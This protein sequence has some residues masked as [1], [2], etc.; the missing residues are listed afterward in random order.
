MIRIFSFGTFLITCAFSCFVLAEEK[1]ETVNIEE[2]NVIAEVLFKDSTKMSP[3]SSITADELNSINITTVEDS[4]AYQPSLIVRKRYIGDPNGVIGIRGSNMFQTPR[5]L[6]FV[7]GMPIHYHLQ[8][9]WNGAPR[10]SLVSPGEISKVDVIYGPFSAEYSGNAMGGVVNIE[11]KVAN[12]QKIRL[13]GAVF[14]QFFERFETNENYTGRNLFASYENSFDNLGFFASYNHLE[15]NSHPMTFHFSRPSNRTATT[16]AV[17]GAISGVDEEGNPGVFYGDSG[18]ELVSTDQYKVKLNYDAGNFESRTIVVF[19]NR[20]RLENDSNNYLRDANGDLIFDRNFSIAGDPDGT[21]YDTT[22]FGTSVFQNR[23]QDRDSLLFGTGISGVIGSSDWV[24][25]SFYSNFQILDDIEVRTGADP[26]DPNFIS[27]NESFRARRTEYDDTGW[28]IF[29]FKTGT[30]SLL[31]INALRLSIGYHYDLYVLEINPVNFNSITGERGSERDSSGGET[32]TSALFVQLGY[33]FSEEWNLALGLRYENWEARDGFIGVPGADDFVEVPKRTESG[34]SPKF[35]IAYFP[36]E[37][38]EIRYSLAR[39]LRFPIVEELFRNE[40][41]GVAQI[42]PDA[43]LN[44]ED[45]IHQ[46]LS[47]RHTLDRGEFQV[48]LFHEVIDDAI[49]TFTEVEFNTQITTALPTEEVTTTGIEFVYSADNLFNSNLDAQL[50][51][52]YANSEITRNALNPDIVGNQFPRMPDWRSNAILRY[53]FSDSFNIS[54]S[55]RYASNSFG[56]L[57]NSD[58]ES[59][60]FGA[61]DEFLLFGL[62]GNWKISND[63]QIGLG[64]ENV[65]DEEVYVHHPWPSRTIFLQGKFE[66]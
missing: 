11:T 44:P 15:N 39:A 48:N 2:V 4:I 51:V 3:T 29:D 55:V 12:E 53:N 46:N 42:V 32:T 49:F 10:W 27:A 13:E 22:S 66:F 20:D 34:F 59:N 50:N 5:S 62:K 36:N 52:T 60:V 63:T 38:I 9:R 56:T 40:N 64:M 24:F 31:G 23:Y 57:E 19:E 14:N 37:D 61:H 43:S 26:Q 45:G 25:D 8:S 30:D 21:V 17:A 47:Y 18:S 54:S 28:Q 41:S 6:V 16:E 33:D 65:T 58:T 1:L 35:S 7:D